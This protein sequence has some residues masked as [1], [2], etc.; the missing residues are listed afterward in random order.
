MTNYLK[1]MMMKEQR[2]SG[3]TKTGGQDPPPIFNDQILL[4]LKT[5]LQRCPHPKART[6]EP[7][8]LLSW[9]V[10]HM[11]SVMTHAQQLFRKTVHNKAELIT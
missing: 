3:T 2:K 7:P 9:P 8:W 11:V 1:L 6:Q 5:L 4:P 10:C